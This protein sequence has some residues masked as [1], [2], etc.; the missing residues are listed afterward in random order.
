LALPST[1]FSLVESKLQF[2]ACWILLSLFLDGIIDGIEI[3]VVQELGAAEGVENFEYRISESRFFK[4]S[5]AIRLKF[6][7]LSF[8]K[9]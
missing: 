2:V 7:N 8:K 9:N 3:L 6:D 5:L 4:F 1:E